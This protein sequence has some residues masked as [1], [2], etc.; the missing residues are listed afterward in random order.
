MSGQVLLQGAVA[1]CCCSSELQGAVAGCCYRPCLRVAQGDV[2]GRDSRVALLHVAVARGGCGAV[3]RSCCREL[4]RA[5]ARVFTGAT[6]VLLVAAAGCCCRA[7][8][9]AAQ[10]PQLR[11]A[12]FRVLLQ[13]AA[14][15]DPQGADADLELRRVLL[16]ESSGAPVRR[17]RGQWSSRSLPGARVGKAV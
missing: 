1:R 2:A 10:L 12:L 5:E 16:Q 7:R 15:R 14:G 8:L 3:A 9:R 11:R 13:G 6:A 4:L 17:D